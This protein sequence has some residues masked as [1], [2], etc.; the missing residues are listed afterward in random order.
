M[1]TSRLV[2]NPYMYVHV[3]LY[4]AFKLVVTFKSVY[5]LCETIRSFMQYLLVLLFCCFM[6]VLPTIPRD[7]R[8]RVAHFLEKQG[9]KQQALA[10]SCDPEHRYIFTYIFIT[11]TNICT[12]FIS[13]V[14]NSGTLTLLK[15]KK[16]FSSQIKF[17]KVQTPSL[18][19]L[20]ISDFACY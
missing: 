15:K 3:V 14:C 20:S 1:L 4:H 7:Q 17:F 18:V 8:N 13:R 2:S 11:K 10:V 5:K 9:F 12:S 16:Y 19:K 6:Q